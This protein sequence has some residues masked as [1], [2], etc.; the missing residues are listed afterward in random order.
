MVEE[1]DEDESPHMDT[2]ET[3]GGAQDIGPAFD[4]DLDSDVVVV[5]I[6]E[7]DRVF[8]TMVHL[9]DPHHFICASSTVSGCLAEASAKNSKPK[10][11]EDTVPTTLHEYADVF[12]ETAFDSLPERRKWDHA[13]KLECEPSPGFRKV[14]LMTLTEQTEMDAF[15]EEALSTRRI[16]QSKSPLG[17]PVFFIKKKDGKLRFIQDYRALNAITRKNCYPL[18]LI[19]D[20]I[21]RLKDVRYFTKLDVRWGYNNV[22]IREGNEWKAA[23]RMNR[24]LFEPLV[25]Y[26]GL[27]NSLATFQTMMNKIFQ[28]L[29]TKGIVSI[30]LNNILIFTNSMEEHR[31][32]T[33]LVLDRMREHKLYL[34]LEKCEFEQTRIE[35]LSVIISHNKVEMDPIKI[36]RVAD[37][38]MPSNKKEVQSFVGFV[39][40]YRHFIPGFSHH[41]R[42]LFDLTM[43][44]IKFIW[45]LP[46]EDYFMKLKELVTSA[47]VLVLPNDDLPFRLEANSS[48]IATSMVLSQQQVGNNAWHP[49][50]F[51]SKALN[52]V[53]WN[54]EIHDTE[55]LAII[56]GLEEWR[57]YLEGARHPVEIWTDHRNLEYF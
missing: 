7:D 33:R 19:D 24:G 45:G 46:Q 26:F 28:D 14:Y 42:A 21:H 57:H 16:R 5:I 52:L 39:N 23:F 51:L 38:P 11:F 41:A 43:K 2:D 35:Y 22:R 1:E 53:E 49:V 17:A 12:S 3:D 15:L 8:M 50:A 9:D 6:E 47:P 55:M 27:T 36:A 44:D 18:P 34:R 40:F 30:Y 31:W 48:G 37:W 56:R 54:Y 32:I 25:M 13:I 4:N 20:L 29:I 10:G